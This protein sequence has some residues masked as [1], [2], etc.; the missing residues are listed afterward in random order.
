[1][2]GKKKKAAKKAEPNPEHYEFIRAFVN[3]DGALRWQYRCHGNLGIGGLLHDADVSEF[4]KDE[5]VKLTRDMLTVEADDPVE[6][7]VIYD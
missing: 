4:S 6:V 7:E 5:I 1:M 3:Q 2:A